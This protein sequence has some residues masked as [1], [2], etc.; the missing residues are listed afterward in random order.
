MVS[1][2]ISEVWL[3]NHISFDVFDRC[4]CKVETRAYETLHS[5]AK[6]LWGLALT[7]LPGASLS[8]NPALGPVFGTRFKRFLNS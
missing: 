8:F 1:P 6:R 4:F 5:C 2:I 7:T 3:P